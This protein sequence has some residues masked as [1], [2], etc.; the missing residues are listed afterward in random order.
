MTAERI[1]TYLRVLSET[2]VKHW[3][4]RAASPNSVSPSGASSSF[5]DLAR[6]DV[7]FRLREQDA[8]D[9]FNE[10][11]IREATRRALHGVAEK[12]VSAGKVVR[13]P[14]TGRSLVVHRYSD[15]LL[16]RL[17]ESQMPDKWNPGRNVKGK[18]EVTH[19]DAGDAGIVLRATDFQQLGAADKSELA[20]ILRVVAANR[21]ER[22]LA[23]DGDYVEVN[24][25]AIEHKPETELP[26]WRTAAWI[27]K[28]SAACFE[29][30]IPMADD[31]EILGFLEV[32]NPAPEA[33][34]DPLA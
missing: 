16:E 19:T 7:E 9:R 6:R 15:R 33:R 8:I 34:L 11:L 28:L 18:L 30:R 5:R 26:N 2:G 12:V 29:W 17:L 21:G 20:R 32:A 13:D 27:A 25:P 4:A 3:S 10:S 31:M 22:D 24:A 14:D 23:E 1:E